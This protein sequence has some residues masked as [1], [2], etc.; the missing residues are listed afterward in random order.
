VDLYVFPKA[1]VE[2][3]LNAVEANPV[4]LDYEVLGIFRAFQLFVPRTQ[5]YTFDSISGC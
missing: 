1:N 2:T 4:E 5:V 3:Q